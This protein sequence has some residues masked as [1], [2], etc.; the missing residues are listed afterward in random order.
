MSFACRDRDLRTKKIKFPVKFPVSREFDVENARHDPAAI[1]LN[2]P[3]ASAGLTMDNVIEQATGT[4]QIEDLC[5]PS[6]AKSSQ[7]WGA[8]QGKARAALNARRRSN[9]RG[10]AMICSRVIMALQTLERL[11]ATGTV[12][13]QVCCSRA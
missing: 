2:K 10:H 9:S 3:L 8:G 7:T 5:W 12:T 11:Q 6:A 1:A 4:R 13:P